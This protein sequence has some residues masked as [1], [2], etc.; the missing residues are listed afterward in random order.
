MEDQVAAGYFFIYLKCL[1]LLYKAA[2]K[3]LE[4]NVQVLQTMAVILLTDNVFYRMYNES[5][6][7]TLFKVAFELNSFIKL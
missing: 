3:C 5:F 4:S 2:L 6:E 7:L 1:F